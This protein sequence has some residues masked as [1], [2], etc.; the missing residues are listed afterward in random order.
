MSKLLG[1]CLLLALS[2]NSKAQDFSFIA[3]QMEPGPLD[4][5]W[6]LTGEISPF[7]DVV[8]DC[9]SFIHEFRF[10]SSKDPSSSFGWYLDTQECHNLENDIFMLIFEGKPACVE[11]YASP[12]EVIIS[13]D[14]KRCYRP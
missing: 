11:L 5:S 13:S 12:Y 14:T 3:E 2:F 1:V 6:I 10:R 8:L 7:D 9:S 4:H